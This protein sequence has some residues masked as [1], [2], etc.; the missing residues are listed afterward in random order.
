MCDNSVSYA[1]EAK[2]QVDGT[3]IEAVPNDLFRIRLVDGR[4][5]LAHIGEASR[6]GIVRLI[7]GDRVRLEITV[8]DPSRARIVARVG[9]KVT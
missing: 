4:Y 8:Y 5:V 9:G 1:S 3:V 7:P 2:N 6:V